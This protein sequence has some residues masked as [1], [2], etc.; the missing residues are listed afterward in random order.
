M[1]TCYTWDDDFT[2]CFDCPDEMD[3]V[4]CY[5][6]APDVKKFTLTESKIRVRENA[7]K[8]IEQLVPDE[9]LR[10]LRSK[11]LLRCEDE[12]EDGPP[13]GEYYSPVM[14]DVLLSP[15]KRL[16]ESDPIFLELQG[17]L[18]SDMSKGEK[19]IAIQKVECEQAVK[20]QAIGAVFTNKSMTEVVVT[21]PRRV[22]STP[23][24]TPGGRPEMEYDPV[25]Y[26][27]FNKMVFCKKL[28]DILQETEKV[29]NVFTEWIARKLN[30]PLTEEELNQGNGYGP[31]T[32]VP[33]YRKINFPNGA[34]IYIDEID[35]QWFQKVTSEKNVP[36]YT[37]FIVAPLNTPEDKFRLGELC[38]SAIG[39][40]GFTHGSLT[41]GKGKV[42]Y[43]LLPLR[44]YVDED[45]E[46]TVAD[47]ESPL[48]RPRIGPTVR[49]E[50]P[51]RPR[52]GRILF[53]PEPGSIY[54]LF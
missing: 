9:I 24:K 53:R 52:T 50:S 27:I 44:N 10:Q 11:E 13:S 42:I 49:I 28:S 15:Q 3:P 14:E 5:T 7:L 12:V 48:K 6:K 30:S 31:K 45:D 39:I 21:P 47:E 32:C 43:T 20:S 16:S 51:L 19:V 35:Y 41:D 29:D 2:Q 54:F 17:I 36:H 26:F 23:R 34:H 33:M 37:E 25:I 18:N 1:S 40:I 8:G 38:M 46:S 4:P 22:R